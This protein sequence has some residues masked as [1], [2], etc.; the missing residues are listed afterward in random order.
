MFSKEFALGSSNGPANNIESSQKRVSYH[1][2]VSPVFRRSID[3]RPDFT[4]HQSFIKSNASDPSQCIKV[5]EF[6]KQELSKTEEAKQG[7]MIE[8]DFNSETQEEKDMNQDLDIMP[9]DLN[10]ELEA[11]S[12]RSSFSSANSSEGRPNYMSEE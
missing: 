4:F 7:Y 1:S 12:R 10:Q 5:G 9:R 6:S 2:A 8:T 3:P 11:V